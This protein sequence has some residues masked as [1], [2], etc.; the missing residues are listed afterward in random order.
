MEAN[1]LEELAVYNIHAR[2]SAP[3]ADK[4]TENSPRAQ[5]GA[6]CDSRLLVS[7]G[8]VAR[9]RADVNASP[10][11]DSDGQLN[12]DENTAVSMQERK[13]LWEEKLS[14]KR[15]HDV[16]KHV[17][18]VG[19]GSGGLKRTKQ[20]LEENLNVSSDSSNGTSNCDRSVDLG[21]DGSHNV[22]Q[23][24]QMWQE[25]ATQ[26]TSPEKPV[27]GHCSPNKS[28]DRTESS[29]QMQLK[30]QQWENY[31]E[32]IGSSPESP[33]ENDLGSQLY[34][35]DE[36]KIDIS[37]E[38][39]SS[40][41]F[42]TSIRNVKQTKSKW[43]TLMADASPEAD[44]P[45]SPREDVVQPP[46]PATKSTSFIRGTKFA[47]L[48]N[49]WQQKWS[50]SLSRATTGHTTLLRLWFTTTSCAQWA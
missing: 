21:L 17:T 28:P 15:G 2:S 30:L 12:E 42:S 43:E 24:K 19:G 48:K 37:N 40:F 13:A 6:H 11:R 26:K 31:Q 18:D 27:N 7:D 34:E 32:N 39:M 44:I 9:T 45:D 23:T 10:S 35:H 50:D 8:L 1:I 4:L 47:S 25:L 41:V 14:W 49:Q 38:H 29:N 36:D 16:T 46:A 33:R 3:H 20:I 22:Q 5:T